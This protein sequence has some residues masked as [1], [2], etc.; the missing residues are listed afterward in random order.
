MPGML[1]AARL[2]LAV[3]ASMSAWPVTAAASFSD[4]DNS[5]NFMEDRLKLVD[6]GSRMEAR[7]H[8]PFCLIQCPPGIL[9]PPSSI[10]YAFLLLLVCGS[11][12]AARAQTIQFLNAAP[13][14]YENG[15][16]VS[17]VVTRIPATGV[18]A[19]EYTTLDG[20]AIAASDYQ[21]T[22]GSLTFNDGESFQIITIPII[23]D[24]VPEGTEG[25][26]VVLSNPSGATLGLATNVVT[27]FDD[28]TILRL[29][30]STFNV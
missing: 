22:T 12:S 30:N 5:M 18:A 3:D 13:S 29:G 14:V 6:R 1:W 25:F 8:H 11:I 4:C 15:T 16:N 19:V 28:D 27:I 17:V 2:R 7:L 20:T 21:L 24:F 26:L 23:N 9:H 10:L